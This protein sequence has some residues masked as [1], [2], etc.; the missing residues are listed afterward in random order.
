MSSIPIQKKKNTRLSAAPAE[1][2]S[3]RPRVSASPSPVPV[4]DVPLYTISTAARLLGVSV[5]TLRMYEREGLILPFQKESGHRLYSDADLER[6]SCIRK[7]INED[8]MSIEGIKRILS[9][10]PCWAVIDCP[11]KDREHCPAYTGHE[12]PCWMLTHR[13]PYC[14][15]RECR[16]CIVYREYTDCGAIKGGIKELLHALGT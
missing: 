9:L 11:K 14:S 10:V 12:G 6:L 1:D 8:R 16:D 2:S 15:G 13:A 3:P 4:S 7:A 5:H